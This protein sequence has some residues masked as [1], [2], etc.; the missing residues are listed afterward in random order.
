M[1]NFSLSKGPADK[2]H[3]MMQALN[4]VKNLSALESKILL[5]YFYPVNKSREVNKNNE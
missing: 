4:H 3:Y 2:H 1:H 5:S